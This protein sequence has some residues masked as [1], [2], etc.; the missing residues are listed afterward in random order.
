MV[1]LV[2]MTAVETENATKENVLATRDSLALTVQ[3]VSVCTNQVDK[4][5]VVKAMSFQKASQ[6]FEVAEY[7]FI[8]V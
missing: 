8:D 7:V 4:M 2:P 1:R 6:D 3:R 5:A